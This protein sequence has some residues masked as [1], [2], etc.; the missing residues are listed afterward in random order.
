MHDVAMT[1]RRARDSRLGHIDWVCAGRV[2]L[3][4]PS[5]ASRAV[6]RVTGLLNE[7]TSRVLVQR[8][9]RYRIDL[10][11]TA[12]APDGV[13]LTPL[14]AETLAQLRQ[15]PDVAQPDL[16]SGLDLWNRGLR[17]AFVWLEDGAPLCMQWLFT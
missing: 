6:A 1:L 12:P 8:W 17:G 13:E 11:R 15:H 14:T 9:I 2:R 3:E 7:R 10:Q 4:G 16:A 5:Q